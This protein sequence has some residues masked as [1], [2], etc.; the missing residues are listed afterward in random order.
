[1]SKIAF[2]FPGQGS[3]Q[4]GAVKDLYNKLSEEN[5]KIADNILNSFD[6]DVKDILLNGSNADLQN[7]KYAQPAITFVSVFLTKLLQEKG[8]V[9]DYVAGHSLGEYSA[10]YATN[11]L[12]ETQTIQLVANRGKIMSEAQID[13]TMAAVLGLD[14][15]KI[16][17]ICNNID[18]VIEAVNYNEP[19]Q[20]VIAGKKDIIDRSVSIFKENG[21]RRVLLL[22]VSGPFHSSLM[23]PV[24]NNIKNLLD[25]LSW[26]NVK[27]PLIANTTATELKSVE[28]IKNELYRQTY[29][30]VKWVDTINYLK[31]QGVEKI[32]EIGTGKILSGLISKIDKTI[33]VINITNVDD[34]D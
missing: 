3:Q 22:D 5:K 1:M 8:I 24:A 26:G 32:Y 33:E 11:A 10:L 31:E 21:A 7:T 15:K 16:E 29:G 19:K 17:D 18:G 14:S 4:S 34:L 13:G 20:T 23:K 2:V 27:I 25:T 30:P 6:E 28:E 12:N 9:A